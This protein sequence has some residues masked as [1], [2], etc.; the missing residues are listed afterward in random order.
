Y[1]IGVEIYTDKNIV[2]VSAFMLFKG[3]AELLGGIVG[4]TITIEAK[5]T[6]KKIGDRTDCRAQVTFAI[7]I[8]IFLVIDINF[9]T[10]W[11]ESRQIA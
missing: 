4:V 11:A 7:D 2:E 8:S 1:M 9:S 5:G 3:H 6:I 10:S